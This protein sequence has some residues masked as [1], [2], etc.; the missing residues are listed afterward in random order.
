MAISINTALRDLVVDAAAANYAGGK[1]RFYSGTPPASAGD[2]A[3]GTL[4]AEI[5]PLPDPAFDA[6]SNGIAAKLG[7]W[8]DTSIDA[9]GTVTYFRLLNPLEA[10]V[11]QG[12]VSLAAGGGDIEVDDVAFNIQGTFTITAFNLSIP[13][14]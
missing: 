4:L 1:M 7:T 3:T 8:A 6:S 2:P 12:S 14:A 9:T 5:A 10:V 11:L 13:A